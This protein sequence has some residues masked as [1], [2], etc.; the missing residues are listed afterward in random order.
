MV[1]RS[2]WE[3]F[4]GFTTIGCHSGLRSCQYV[5]RR[6]SFWSRTINTFFFLEESSIGQFV[7]SSFKSTHQFKHPRP[8]TSPFP[9]RPFSRPL[10]HQGR[11][12]GA[13][14]WALTPTR[15][16]LNWDMGRRVVTGVTGFLWVQRDAKSK[17]FL[18]MSWGMCSLTYDSSILSKCRLLPVLHGTRFPGC[19]HTCW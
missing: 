15:D 7:W 11:G 18:K 8:V 12:S 3:H 14:A 9:I 19:L 5:D 2:R 10:C 16:R 17:C 1:I 6:L 4:I 13:T